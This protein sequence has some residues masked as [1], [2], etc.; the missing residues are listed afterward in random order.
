MNRRKCCKQPES[1]PCTAVGKRGPCSLC[2]DT[3]KISAR[4]KA[5]HADPE[6]AA[7]R[8]ALASARIKALNADPEFAARRDARLK[9]LN[10]DPEFAARRRVD[11]TPEM[12]AALITL[13]ELGYG[14][15]LIAER[16]GVALGT[17][18]KR[19]HQLGLPPGDR[20]RR[21]RRRA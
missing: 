7:R 6:F 13:R 15:V 21:E 8:D 1:E 2:T 5:L 9:A 17:C 12:D 19:I 16:I 18:S 4:L 11:W 10:A 14:T 20:G 3:S